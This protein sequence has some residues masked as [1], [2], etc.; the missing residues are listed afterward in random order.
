[1]NNLMLRVNRACCTT[2]ER[3]LYVDCPIYSE[4]NRER[5]VLG[6]QCFACILFDH[7]WGMP[8][9]LMTINLSVFDQ[10]KKNKSIKNVDFHDKVTIFNCQNDNLFVDIF[11]LSDEQKHTLKDY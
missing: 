9:I 7:F 2:L 8:Y 3:Y 1:M 5:L 10:T 6:T 4:H 11:F